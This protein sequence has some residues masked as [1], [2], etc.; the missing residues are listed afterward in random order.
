MRCVRFT[1]TATRKKRIVT[2]DLY[3]EK[4]AKFRTRSPRSFGSHSQF[5][6][7]AATNNPPYTM[8]GNRQLPT[9]A[10]TAT[11]GTQIADA[12]P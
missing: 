9:S 7:S 5:A 8:N 1:A 4:Y 2:S 11:N 3:L 12:R 6:A 10:S